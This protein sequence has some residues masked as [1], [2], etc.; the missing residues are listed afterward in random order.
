M[1]RLGQSGNDDDHVYY[2][3]YGLIS[4]STISFIGKHN[5]ICLYYL[6]HARPSAYPRPHTSQITDIISE[7]L[8]SLDTPPAV[9]IARLYLLSDIVYN[10][11]AKGT[12]ASAYRK[13]YETCKAH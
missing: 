9:K 1:R 4:S 13:T 6:K 7:S 10:S 11:T 3:N 8:A 5:M 2:L 12:G